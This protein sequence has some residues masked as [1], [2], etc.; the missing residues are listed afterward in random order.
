MEIYFFQVINTIGPITIG[1]QL[2][3]LGLIFTIWFNWEALKLINGHKNKLSKFSF[4]IGL[5][6]ILFAGLLTVDT[7]LRLIKAIDLKYMLG[8]LLFLFG[9]EFIF[10]TTIMIQAIGTLKKHLRSESTTANK[11]LL[12]SGGTV[13]H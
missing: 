6:T 9:L 10:A 7:I 8:G 12:Q 3:A 1:D 11:S 13:R 4:A 5:I 2:S